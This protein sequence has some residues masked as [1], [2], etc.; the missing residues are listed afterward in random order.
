M[1]EFARLVDETGNAE[2]KKLRK[3]AA[4]HSKGQD[5]KGKKKDQPVALDDVK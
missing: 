1:S 4:K 3:L 2:A 5:G